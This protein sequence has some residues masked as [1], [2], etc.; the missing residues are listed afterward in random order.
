[1]AR[2]GLRCGL[3]GTLARALDGERSL[4]LFRVCQETL[5]NVVRHAG[6]RSVAVR[7]DDD[8]EVVT[9]TIRD[10]GIGIDPLAAARGRSFGILGMSER[11]RALDGVLEVARAP[12]GGTIV[13]AR[14]PR[15]DH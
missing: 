1:R 14:L 9:L 7:L 11:L 6:A 4:A 12:G 13:R 2:T 3:S 5:T 10:D 15:G 8:G